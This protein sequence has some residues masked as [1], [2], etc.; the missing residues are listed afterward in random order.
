MLVAGGG[1][2]GGAPAAAAKAGQLRSSVS[3]VSFYRL[4]ALT[5]FLERQGEPGIHSH[6]LVSGLRHRAPCGPAA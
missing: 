6:L 4:A 1:G 2:G 5:Y 3:Q